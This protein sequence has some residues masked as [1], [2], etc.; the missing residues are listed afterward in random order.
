LFT[1]DTVP[2]IKEVWALGNNTRQKVVIKEKLEDGQKIKALGG[3]PRVNSPFLHMVGT[4][5]YA[6][7]CKYPSAPVCHSPAY[8]STKSGSLSHPGSGEYFHLALALSSSLA[9]SDHNKLCTAL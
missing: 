8:S 3:S 1:F 5:K 7:P 9:A 4:S 6:G 2:P